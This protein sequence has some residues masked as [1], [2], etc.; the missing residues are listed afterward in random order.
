VQGI[1]NA[2]GE[3]TTN[4]LSGFQCHP[5]SPLVC[6]SPTTA[7][8]VI[9]GTS[10][11]SSNCGL[12]SVTITA[13]AETSAYDY[14]R[15]PTHAAVMLLS[16][17]KPTGEHVVP[18]LLTRPQEIAVAVCSILGGLFVLWIGWRILWRRSKAKVARLQLGQ[19]PPPGQSMRAIR[20]SQDLAD[21]HREAA[22][23]PYSLT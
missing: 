15:G 6:Y 5:S 12:L 2:S 7:G 22:P 4:Q 16:G 8:Q 9:A 10:Y 21:T 14:P 19:G 3:L 23:P 1:S 11:D 18:G 13:T 17:A 20:H